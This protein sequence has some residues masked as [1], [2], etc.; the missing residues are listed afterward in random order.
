[1]LATPAVRCGTSSARTRCCSTSTT[2]RWAH[3]TK[4][5][6]NDSSEWIWSDKPVHEPLIDTSD[7]ERAQ[8]LLAAKGRRAVAREPRRNNRTYVPR[9]LCH[10]GLCDRRMQGNW[11]NDAPYYRCRYPQQYALANNIDHPK[12][13]QVREDEI[14]EVLD[15]W[16]AGVSSPQRI[17]DTVTIL[18][19]S[20]GDDPGQDAMEI[21]ARQML[22][23]RDRKLEL[24]RAALEAG[25]DPEIV[26][27]RTDEVKAQRAAAQAQLQVL[28]DRPAVWRRRR[29]LP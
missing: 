2:W 24:H 27:K 23:D 7:L 20:Q 19:R 10:C 8:T 11:T 29:S 14:L 12:S 13:V 9:S 6:W 3:A 17:D 5:R 18:E 28:D 22:A 1:M 25:T 21:A 16:V 15:G 26:K 4:L